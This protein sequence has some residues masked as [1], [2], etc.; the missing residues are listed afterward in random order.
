MKR[1]NN[2]GKVLEFCFP[3]SVRILVLHSSQTFILLTCSIPLVSRV[4]NSVDPDQM[5]LSEAS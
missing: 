3:I 4:E 2:P 1:E 5:A